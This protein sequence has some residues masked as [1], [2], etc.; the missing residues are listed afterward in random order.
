MDKTDT[1]ATGPGQRTVRT[2]PSE[3][4]LERGLEVLEHHGIKG[5]KWGVRR[6][7]G[8]GSSGGHA[9]GGHSTSADAAKAHELASRA[10][11]SGTHTLSN[12]ELEHLTK[13]MNL[14]TQYSRLTSVGGSRHAAGAKFAGDLLKQV[15]K[16]QAARLASEA[17]TKAVSKA[18][19]K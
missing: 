5:M 2:D 14:E 1:A 13:R 9:G 6:S 18:L 17:A 8:S 7:G 3:R 19:K 11:T 4:F 10:K 12:Q 15:G 16:Q